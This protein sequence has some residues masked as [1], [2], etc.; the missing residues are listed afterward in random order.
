MK[1]EKKRGFGEGVRHLER[2]KVEKR[3]SYKR[4][5]KKLDKTVMD[6]TT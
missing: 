4:K 5:I 3:K 1:L 2:V 6:L